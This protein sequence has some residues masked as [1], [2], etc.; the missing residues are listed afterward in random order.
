M[1][2]NRRQFLKLSAF[3]STLFA[4]NRSKHAS[5]ILENAS[6]LQIKNS[7]V[8]FN[9][10][11][12]GL[13]S[14]VVI[15][16][17]E[18][19]K[20]SVDLHL[21]NIFT[22]QIQSKSIA[23]SLE[24][25][26]QQKSD[27]INTSA[28]VKPWHV[29]INDL[30][31]IGNKIA[32]NISG[33]S[34]TPLQFN[35]NHINYNQVDVEAQNILYT[36]D[37]IAVV[38]SNVRAVNDQMSLKTMSV[39]FL[40]TPHSINATKLLA[41]TEGSSIVADLSLK[42]HSLS[43]LKDSLTTL[44]IDADFKN[45]KVNAG[46]VT[47]FNNELKNQP[48]FFNS[49]STVSVNG[50]IEGTVNN[51][52]SENLMVSS[53][54]QTVLKT[55]FIITGLP[56]ANKAYFSFPSLQ[57]HSGKDDLAALLGKKL[58]PSGIELPAV[59]SL[60][61]VYKGTVKAFSAHA[62]LASTFGSLKAYAEVDQ[63]ENFTAEVITDHFN[64]GKLLKDEKMFGPVN[65]TINLNGKG[66][67]W[68][69]MQ[70]E[71]K[72]IAGSFFL[73]NYTYHDLTLNAT[74]AQKQ[75]T[76]NAELNDTNLRFNLNADATFADKNLSLN[77]YLQVKAADLKKLG[78][79]KD[80]LR[81][82]TT[83]IAKFAGPD[84]DHL[85][86]ELSLTATTL[87]SNDKVFTI[88]SLFRLSLNTQPSS[89]KQLKNS[90]VDVNFNGNVS[91]LKAGAKLN[92]YVSSYLTLAA[93]SASVKKNI[94]DTSRF[95]FE[96][97]IRNHPVISEA[98]LPG[99]EEFQP[100]K[101]T[102]LFV[103]E[104]KKLIVRTSI[105]KLSY[106]GIGTSDLNFLVNGNAERI[107]YALGIGDVGTSDYSLEN[108]NITGRVANRAATLNLSSEEEAGYKKIAFKTTINNINEGWKIAFRPDAFYL[109]DW[110]WEL[111]AD[112]Y[113][114]LA[115]KG[116]IIHKLDFR[117]ENRMM[118]FNSVNNKVNDDISVWFN[119][120]DLASLSDI[121]ERDSALVEGI[122]DGNIFLKRINNTYGFTSDLVVSL[123]KF[124]NNAVGDLSLKA[125]RFEDKKFDLNA[126]LTGNGN[127]VTVK[128]FLQPQQ[129]VTALNLDA[130]IK[131]LSMKSAEAFSMGQIT[132]G[133]GNL[134]GN[135]SVRGNSAQPNVNGTINF[136]DV[137]AR[138]A[139][140][141]NRLHIANEKI[142]LTNEGISFNNFSFNDEENHTAVLNGK[143]GMKNFSDF[144]F[145]LN[146]RTDDFMVFNTSSKD[147]ELYYGKLLMDSRITIKGTPDF[148]AI[149]SR[150]KI[151]KGSN[152]TFAVPEDKLSVD[153]GEG[154]IV[155]KDTASQNPFLLPLDSKKQESAKLKGYDISST[156]EIEKD[157]VL[158][159]FIDPSSKDS[160]V[161]QGE[162]AL[163][164]AIDPSGKI[165]LTGTYNL[166]DGSYLVSIE[167]VVKK[168]FVIDPGSTITWNGDPLDADVNIN[169][170]YKIRT[171]PIDLVADQLGGLSDADKNAYRSRIPFLVYLKLRGPILK[172]EISFEVQLP[173]DEKGALG[174]A[175]NARLATLNEDPSALNKQVFA[176]LVL[177]RFIQENPLQTESGAGVSTVARNSVSRFL[178]QQLNQYGANIIP[179][180]ELNF[181]VQSYD[182]YS[183]GSQ[184]GRTELGVGVRKQLFNEKLSVQVGGS[185]DVEG[186]KA[187]QNSA[188][189][190]TGD[191]T[192][193]YKLTDDGRYRLKGFR[194]NEYEGAIDGQLVE[195]GAGIV[196]TRDFNKWKDFFKR[197]RK[198][199][200]RM[201]TKEEQ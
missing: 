134:S 140:L 105:N 99:L 182:D 179:G 191:V 146:V 14:N 60:N 12:S 164:F 85:Q 194:H 29:N 18:I 92:N 43:T 159:L 90:L 25:P 192:V 139:A 121:V 64:A 13:K 138:P 176:L 42:Y 180:V 32:Y 158:K 172:P 101:I 51:L 97:A 16:K 46:D 44:H 52:R 30:K 93:D 157:A 40:M 116:F 3:A 122:V 173:Q 187:N 144:I 10:N 36:G 2:T 72:V 9:D 50:K 148:P 149:A 142:A 189:D 76:A 175:V 155:F 7:D 135:F 88:D 68:D 117:N 59:F 133:A 129:D 106:K 38:V 54:K 132:D 81:T 21:Q 160:L 125:S 31:L 154:I 77:T 74:K 145:D 170:I 166:T 56:D 171:S 143:V 104:E 23:F 24:Q 15:P 169:A 199:N 39:D 156:I 196:Y 70:A 19:K 37:S 136:N 197:P 186:E 184:Q 66:L 83:L 195:T 103:A 96:V 150:I 178:T 67:L 163:S 167:G 110:L 190:I 69:K 63:A 5:T 102:G 73:N 113:L 193:E 123:I 198:T 188:S 22:D 152:F 95:D 161:V 118:S 84:E 48:F 35:P 4:C 47:Y 11:I 124:R 86:G 94:S 33:T 162:A 80:D 6:K 26:Q 53:G 61:A 107:S 128:G 109:A 98:L 49:S 27:D 87:A 168:R 183:N 165:S 201:K 100:G 58:L 126:S 151:I 55:A 1:N 57:L 153:K 200:E 131:T 130:V 120:F 112:N 78:V 28:E 91:P 111:P 119:K 65:A 177:G 75:I 108:I 174:G 89:T 45:T 20:A 141:N 82:G 185:V 114:L 115:D 127:D 147:N 137:Y 62:G 17:M 181:D 79:T 34:D 71:A 41:Q 8:N